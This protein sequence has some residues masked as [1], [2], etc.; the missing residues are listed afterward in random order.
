MEHPPRPH[1]AVLDAASALHKGKITRREFVHFATLL[2]VSLPMAAKLSAPAIAAAGPNQAPAKPRLSG[3]RTSQYGGTWKSAMRVDKI[4]HPARIFWSG[5]SNLIR[6]VCEKLTEIG[7]DNLVRPHLLSGWETSADLKTWT[8]HLRQD[9]TFN[10][11]DP[12]NADDVLFTFSQWLDTTI[13]S[14]MLGILSYLG[15]INNVEK[16]DA[17]TLRLHLKEPTI[18]LPDDLAQNSAFILHHNFAGEFLKQPIGTGAFLLDQYL[19]GERAE[20]I[21][22][23]DYWRKST[24][25]ETLPYLDRLTFISLAPDAAV[26]ALQAGAVDSLY[27][28]RLQDWQALRENANLTIQ[29][30]RTSSVFLGRMR[31]DVAPW[32]DVRVRQA[33]K[34]CQDR[35]KINEL[36]YAGQG[37]LGIDAHIAPSLP[38]Y[39]PKPFPAYAPARAKELLEAYAQ[40]KGLQL[41]LKVTLATKND[42]QEPQLA[43]ALKQLAQ[44]AGFDITLDIT[45]PDGYWNRWTEVPLGITHWAHR[46]PGLS[47]LRLAYTADSSGNPLP[48]NET[49]WLDSE[50]ITQLKAA[51]STLDVEERRLIMSQLEDIMQTRGPVFVSFWNSTWNI[52]RR[53]FHHVKGY[54][55]NDD[56]MDEVW[57]ESGQTAP[58]YLP[59]IAH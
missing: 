7:P 24:H 55:L 42:L 54:P 46:S 16:V 29:W 1:Q 2:G 53:E 47:S 11:G 28:P 8:L 40:E 32:D 58:V 23:P 37:D 18:S 50:F 39:A 22:R 21:R 48:W 57:K 38:E 4:D 10:N 34:L 12:L 30:V 36:A 35:L 20:L 49:R 15:G 14:S 31:V 43:Q 51:Q 27:Q 19:E 56:L 17:F 26:T 13:G 6:Q 5:Q 45:D 52:T 3:F 44:P 41:P 33:L 9:V 59:L 25:G